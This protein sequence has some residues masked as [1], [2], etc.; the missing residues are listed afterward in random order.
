MH[1]SMFN[2]HCSPKHNLMFSKITDFPAY[3][4]EVQ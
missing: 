4:Y 3:S 1:I 2:K